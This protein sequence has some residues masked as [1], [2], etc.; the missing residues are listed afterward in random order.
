MK[1]FKWPETHVYFYK[2][3]WT[4]QQGERNPPFFEKSANPV[5]STAHAAFCLKAP[6]VSYRTVAKISLNK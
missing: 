4:L 1:H 6:L 3:F 5:A 2:N